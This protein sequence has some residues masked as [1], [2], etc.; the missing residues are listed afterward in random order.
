[1]T[2]ETSPPPLLMANLREAKSVVKA[3]TAIFRSQLI[4]MADYPSLQK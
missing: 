4:A 3:S 1:M 2:A